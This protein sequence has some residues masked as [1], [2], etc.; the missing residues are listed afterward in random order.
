MK[1]ITLF[2]ALFFSAQSFAI[3]IED[4]DTS[5][6]YN[7][8]DVNVIMACDAPESNVKNWYVL[9][10]VNYSDPQLFFLSKG[11]L[12]H[13]DKQR[14]LSGFDNGRLYEIRAGFLTYHFNRTIPGQYKLLIMNG[15]GKKV[16]LLPCRDRIQ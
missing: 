3:I 16:D 15:Y 1:M 5:L 13:A 10:T 7:I 6:R 14:N 2:M 9:G 8:S 12:V 11:M 4:R